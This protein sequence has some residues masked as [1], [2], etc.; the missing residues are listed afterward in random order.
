MLVADVDSPF[1]AQLIGEQPQL[2]ASIQL[3]APE[4]VGKMPAGSDSL[5]TISL[6]SEP[7]GVGSISQSP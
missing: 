1:D 4:T 6:A 2:A 3:E 7:A 5:P